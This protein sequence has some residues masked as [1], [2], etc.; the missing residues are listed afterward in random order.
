M[1]RNKNRLLVTGVS[2]ML[3]SNLDYYFKN[4]YDVLG[5]YNSHP[6]WIDGISTEKCDL[7]Q[8]NNIKTI[9]K[10]YNPHIIAHCASLTNI[11]EC[12]TNK[13][14]TKKINVFATKDIVDEVIH[15]DVQLVYISSDS[16]Y[17]G[18]KGNF[19]EGDEIN[20]QNYYGL[21]KY[22]GELEVSRHQKSLIFRTNCSLSISFNKIFSN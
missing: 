9:I 18:L 1:M 17:D 10:N 3:G 11:D 6:V 21:S 7:S 12:E 13:E 22:E 5:L 8:P 4:K 16:V 19:S 2:G 15:R 14:I 20:P